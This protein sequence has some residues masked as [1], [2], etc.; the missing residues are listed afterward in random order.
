VNELKQALARAGYVFTDA[1][2][3]RFVSSVDINNDGKLSFQG[4]K[5]YL[6]LF[7]SKIKIIN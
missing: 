3:A 6:N 2:I 4:K 7:F 1:E 5:T